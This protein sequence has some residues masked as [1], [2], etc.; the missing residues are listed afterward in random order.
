MPAYLAE[1]PSGHLMFLPDIHN[2]DQARRALGAGTLTEVPQQVLQRARPQMFMTDADRRSDE[3]KAVI[4]AAR[5]LC[6]TLSH[7]KQALEARSS[8]N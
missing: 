7:L 5:R 3:G 4:A 6:P 8:L 1:W 2:G